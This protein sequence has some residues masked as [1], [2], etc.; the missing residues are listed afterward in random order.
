M[1]RKN[2]SII[3]DVTGSYILAS[4]FKDIHE[5]DAYF[6]FSNRDGIDQLSPNRLRI[7]FNLNTK[8][9]ELYF[10][11]SERVIKLV[12]PITKRQN[13]ARTKMKLTK[14]YIDDFCDLIPKIRL[15]LQNQIAANNKVLGPDPIVK[16]V[17]DKA[18][19]QKRGMARKKVKNM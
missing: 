8:T 18:A 1:R 14:D 5:Y 12:I 9:P 2:K 10:P 13:N 16:K 15:S 3:R 4:V 19:Q 6:E 17:I 7:T 11:D